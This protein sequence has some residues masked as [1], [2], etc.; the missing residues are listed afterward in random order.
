MNCLSAWWRSGTIVS[1][2]SGLTSG[3]RWLGNGRV[4]AVLGHGLAI[5]GLDLRG[6]PRSPV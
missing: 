1:E 5:A 2:P 3:S 6:T 4:D